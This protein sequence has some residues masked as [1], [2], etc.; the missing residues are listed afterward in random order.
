MIIS[1]SM[2]PRGRRR[3]TER[4]GSGA[5]GRREGRRD[6]QWLADAAPNRT[7]TPAV[8]FQKIA[9]RDDARTIYSPRESTG[10]GR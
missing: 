10:Q 2:F 8:V 1:G 9:T 3:W 7:H 5:A 6:A 4:E